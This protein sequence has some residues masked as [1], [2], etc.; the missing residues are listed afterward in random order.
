LS[1][2]VDDF[3]F[4][5]FGLSFLSYQIVNLV[6]VHWTKS[7]SVL[8]SSLDIWFFFK[9]TKNIFQL[10]EFFVEML[11]GGGGVVKKEAFRKGSGKCFE[12][13]YRHN[14]ATQKY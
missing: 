7:S 5:S 6:M 4:L 2:Q 3:S 1:T 11:P 14:V 10:R 13:M 12:N 9:G 8:N